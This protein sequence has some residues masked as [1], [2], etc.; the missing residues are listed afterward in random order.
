MI[1]KLPPQPNKCILEQ[2]QALGVRVPA[3]CGGN[4]SCGK[5]RIRVVD[6]Y[7]KT[8]TRD[9][10]IF[11]SAK[12]AEGWRLAC[13]S[14]SDGGL[15]VD[16]PDTWES[17]NVEIT[18]RTPQ[19]MWGGEKCGIVV[20]LGTT[21]V[22]C[23]L[24]NSNGDIVESRSFLNPQEAFGADVISR[25]KASNDGDAEVLQTMITHK[26]RETVGE[27]IR[28]NISCIVLAGNTTMLHLLRGYDCEGLAQFPFK[29]VNL[30]GETLD[31]GELLGS[32]T[33]GT[34]LYIL[35]GISA[36]IGADIVSGI[37][38]LDLDMKGKATLLMDLGTNGEMVLSE[39]GNLF[40]ASAA[41]GPAFEGG[42]ISCGTG[43]VPG[44][45]KSVRINNGITETEV[46]GNAKP[47]G[48]CGS[49]V[50][51]LVSE[52]LREKIVDGY[53]TF[54]DEYFNSGFAFAADANG[55]K[56]VLSQKDI[57]ELQLAKGAVRAVAEL[58]ISGKPDVNDVLLSGGFSR[59]MNIPRIKELGIFPENAIITS[60][61]NS[62]ILGLQKIAAGFM[63]GRKKETLERLNHIAHLTQ[64]VPVAGEPEFET[65]FLRYMNFES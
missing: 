59:G 51:E 28:P 41:A 27:L 25:I 16:I 10:N 8:G 57:R 56:L 58:L 36:F 31:A 11:G 17:E 2:L 14:Y 15:T 45:V 60:V 40:A 47:I 24:V 18:D 39:N 43:C 62:C 65:L 42:N 13:T 4:G 9:I 21:T 7:V 12:C 52:L 33:A 5:C 34:E 50:L 37:Y 19:I 20:D 64:E 49:G 63:N 46:V 53:G 3:A 38:G 54:R 1:I 61:G 23:A 35:P 30:E 32:E 6:G 55:E 26:L 44:A 48:I 22:V 29:P